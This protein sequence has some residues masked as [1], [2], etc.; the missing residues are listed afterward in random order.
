MTWTIIFIALATAALVTLVVALEERRHAR[1]QIE[2][3][4]TKA[5]SRESARRHEEFMAWI[6][7]EHKQKRHLTL[8]P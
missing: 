1:W 7:P 2:F 6:D 5:E 4:K 8:I 3:D